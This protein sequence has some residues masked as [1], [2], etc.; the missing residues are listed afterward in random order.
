MLRAGDS[1]ADMT[2]LTLYT[3]VPSRGF[4][5]QWLLAEL[6][7]PY[8]LKLLDLD[9][10]QHKE[11]DYLAINPMGKVPSLV[12]DGAVVTEAAAISMY[13]AELYPAKGLSVAVGSP[14]RASYLR[15]CFYGPVTIEPALIAKAF[16]LTHPDYQAFADVEV[17][18]ETL[19]LA[20][21][22]REFIVGDS[23]TAADIAIG[24]A[25]YWGL[26]LMPVLP[27]H[28]E[29]V[30]YW[31]RLAKRPAWKATMGTAD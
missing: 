30:S 2:E 14:L 8:E 12:H 4:M 6:D 13:L 26:E 19:R 22:D 5:N 20:L 3:A 7:V 11:S 16:D 10:N 1:L 18:G 24:S 25:I 21:T 28:P 29:L 17:V 23:F 15:W 27:K 31:T 9:K